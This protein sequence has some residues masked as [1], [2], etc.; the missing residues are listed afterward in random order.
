MDPGIE[1]D[2]IQQALLPALGGIDRRLDAQPGRGAV[3]ERLTAVPARRVVSAPGGG[4][5][6]YR[7]AYRLGDLDEPFSRLVDA[8]GARFYEFVGNPDIHSF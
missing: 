2:D 4:H 5:R 8:A 1:G 6:D 7:Q 3:Q